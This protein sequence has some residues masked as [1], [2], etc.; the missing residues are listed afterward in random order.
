M[1]W[2]LSCR[3]RKSL[4]RICK[5]SWSGLRIRVPISFL[6]CGAG[7]GEQSAG[8]T[9]GR[10]PTPR[11]SPWS[12]YIFPETF[13]GTCVDTCRSKTSSRCGPALLGCGPRFPGIAAFSFAER[14]LPSGRILRTRGAGRTC[15]ASP[16]AA[17]TLSLSESSREDAEWHTG[18]T[19]R[20]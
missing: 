13:C 10:P 16:C 7:Q 18:P 5:I 19:A 15:T 17:A 2:L 4:N 1:R 9:A 20:N 3:K 14:R 8:R 6:A 12:S 11:S